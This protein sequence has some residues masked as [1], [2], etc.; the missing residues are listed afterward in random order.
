[1]TFDAAID[2]TA[3][4]VNRFHTV[5]MDLS[6]NTNVAGYSDC[7]GSPSLPLKLNL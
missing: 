2:N 7:T 5:T 3:S 6:P 4:Y 1:V